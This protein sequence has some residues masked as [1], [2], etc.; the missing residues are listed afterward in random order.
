MSF[1][2]ITLPFTLISL[3]DAGCRTILN[4]YLTSLHRNIIL[5]DLMPPVVEPAMPQHTPISTSM[6]SERTGQE[7]LSAML[8]PVVEAKLM[9]WK[10]PERKERPQAS[11]NPCA[12]IEIDTITPA[13]TIME[14]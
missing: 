11:S 10:K 9:T 8:N 6:V 3:T 7:L 1:C 4:W 13:T 12:L 5:S 2:R 14:R